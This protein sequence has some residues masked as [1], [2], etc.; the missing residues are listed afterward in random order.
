MPTVFS[1]LRVSHPGLVVEPAFYTVLRT[2]FQRF[3]SRDHV[4]KQSRLRG[5]R[6]SEALDRQL[7]Q[8]V[9]HRGFS[10]ASAFIRAAIEKELNGTGSVDSQAEERIAASF[11]RI[12]RELRK[13]A[14]AQQALFAFTDALAR[15]FLHCIPEPA[16]GSHEQSLARAK[17]RHHRLLKMAALS[18]Q[19][20]ARAAMLELVDRVE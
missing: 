6:V 20:D 18:M 5:V 12:S 14:N 8:A 16:A 13:L 9:R 19:G 17:E 10:N 11:D 3:S 7:E 4:Q 1:D 15:V 2:P